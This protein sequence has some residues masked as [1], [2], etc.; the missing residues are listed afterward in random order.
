MILIVPWIDPGSIHPKISNRLIFYRKKV[1]VIRQKMLMKILVYACSKGILR[2]SFFSTRRKNNSTRGF[3]ANEWRRITRTWKIHARVRVRKKLR[4]KRK[5]PDCAYPI[6]TIR[7][8]SF[9]N[10]SSVDSKF[11]FIFFYKMGRLN[12][13]YIFKYFKTQLRILIRFAETKWSISSSRV[14]QKSLQD[15]EN[16][17]N[18]AN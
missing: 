8:K 11:L 17:F 7:R 14:C 18:G 4:A 12:W 16:H 1:R 9:L 6:L 13:L 5:I 2:V 10:D 3:F 15:A